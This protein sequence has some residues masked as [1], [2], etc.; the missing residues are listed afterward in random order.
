MLLFE[1]DEPRRDCGTRTEPEFSVLEKPTS[2]DVVTKL[3]SAEQNIP[4][5]IPTV[6]I[7]VLHVAVRKKLLIPH[8]TAFAMH[9]VVTDNSRATATAQALYK[10]GAVVRNANNCS[11]VSMLYSS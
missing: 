2:S 7:E 1:G 4:Y 8:G 6:P 11:T 10:G 5:C 3:R 9:I